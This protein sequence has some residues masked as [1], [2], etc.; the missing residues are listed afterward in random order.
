G[1][2]RTALALTAAEASGEGTLLLAPRRAAA[3]RLRDALAVHGAG[4]VRAMTPP[5]LGHAITRAQALR[6]GLAEPTRPTAAEQDALLPELLA[7]REGWHLDVAPGARQLPSFRTELRALIT[8][9]AEL[10][11]APADLEALGHERARP[12]WLDAAALL[13]DYLG[14]L[15]LEASAALDAG[16]RLDS[17]ALVRRAV[18]L[19]A[20]PTTPP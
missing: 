5:A 7:Q 16:P 9:A 12:A 18:R 1:S 10:G 6:R 15:D 17:G 11:L 4:Q 20:D 3:G 19:L 8:R 14:V 13:R 2:G